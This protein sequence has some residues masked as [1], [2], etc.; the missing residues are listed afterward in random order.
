[1]S[2]NDIINTD[3]I[4]RI[5]LVDDQPIIAE[6]IRRMLANET[7]M[8]LTYI[9]DPA[10]AIE[11][12]VDLDAT[13]ILQDLVMPD[14]DGMTLLR[15]YKANHETRDIPVIVLSSKEEATTK[16][17]AFSYGASDYLVK[18]PDEIEL[19]ARIRSHAKNYILQKERDSAFYALSQLKK[20]LESSNKQLHKL[21]M[22]DGLTGISNRR[23]FDEQLESDMDDARENQT[24]VTL[25]LMDIDYFKVFNDSY[26]HQLGDE[27][28][29]EV[30]ALLAKACF[31]PQDMAARYGG[32]EFVVLLPGTTEIN[33]L[34]VAK[35]FA[36]SLKKAQIEHKDSDANEYVTVSMGIATHDKGSKYDVKS[37]IEDAD[38]ALYKAKENGRNRV[39]LASEN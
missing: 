38:K 36:E 33:A 9:E 20:Q 7:D 27:C 26:G 6:G 28:L 15:F 10:L 37:L 22:Q 32:E 23:H 34:K 18:L 11:S 30:G 14:A 8:E 35:R 13:I 39:E 4:I 1:M 19:I 24:P 5:M 31:N 2:K 21:S 29:K 3:K 12:A 17:E 16:S 25:I